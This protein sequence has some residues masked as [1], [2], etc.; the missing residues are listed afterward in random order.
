MKSM[1]DRPDLQKQRPDDVGSL[2]GSVASF[3]FCHNICQTTGQ[4]HHQQRSPLFL[5][6]AVELG[7]LCQSL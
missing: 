1:R 5:I 6:L 2:V 4:V 3:C 7:I